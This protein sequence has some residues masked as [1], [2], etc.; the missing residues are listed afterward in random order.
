MSA[1]PEAVVDDMLNVIID[2]VE[3]KARQGAMIIEVTDDNDISVPRF[4]YHKKLPIAANCRMCMV[5]VEMGGRMA[6]KPLPACATPVADGMKVW[7]QSEY[8]R[9][10]Q[11]AVMEFLLI[12][13]PLDC[14]ICDQGGECELQDVALEYGRGVSRFSEKKRVVPEKN[15]GP[16]IASDMTRCIHCTRCVRFLEHVAGFK[17]L[18]GMGR[19]EN[20]EIG[21]CIQHNIES[22]LSGNII[23]VCPVGALTS[24]PFR[25][26]ARAWELVQTPSVA[27]HDCVGSNIYLHTRNG[28]LMR[29]VPR[30][31]EAINEVWAA[32]RDRF[33]YQGINSDDRL[34]TPMVKRA[35][36]WQEVE[37]EEALHITAQA[38]SER[39]KEQG[40]DQLGMLASP[41]ATL[42]ELSLFNQLAEGLGVSN[43][44]HRLR[45]TDF[46]GQAQ[47]PMFP[48]LGQTIEEL[49]QANAILVVGGNLRKDHPIIGHRIRKA[50]QAGASVMMINPVDYP[51]T[52][53]LAHKSIVTPSNL[54][55]SLSGVA[56]ALLQSR[57]A[58]APEA[59]Q[60]VIEQTLP[61]DT[62]QAMAA[63]LADADNATVLLGLDAMMHPAFSALRAI[64]VLIGDLSGARVGF[65]SDGA[66]SAG[67]CLAGVLPHHGAGG[68]V[69][70]NTGL[71]AAQMLAQPRRNY[72]LLNIEPEFDCAN[73]A[74]AL[75][76]MQQAGFVVALTPYVTD[77][78]RNY[79]D[80]LLP[81][82]VFAET[83]GTFVTV[84]GRWQ[85]FAAASRAPGDTRPGWKILRVLG[86]L[87]DLEGFDQVSSE[88]VRDALS[89]QVGEVKLDNSTCGDAA[90]PPAP[91][92]GLERIA[93]LP[94]YAV[95]NIVRRAESLQLTPDGQV[96]LLRLNPDDA[97]SLSLADGDR[98]TVTEDGNSVTLEVVV[99]ERVAKGAAVAPQAIE[100]TL[101]LG[102]PSGV[103]QV[104]KA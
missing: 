52:Y 44:D 78:M 16:L 80:V 56:A 90:T 86:N 72:L 65:V 71:D 48:F 102:A 6:P 43:I 88:Q 68:A 51:V 40:A 17:E 76:A 26:S 62:E 5:Q 14:P 69:R 73:G 33:S 89:Q 35:D 1:K 30:E 29:V 21:T 93:S 55:Q 50:A 95:D 87:L 41:S 31:N 13:H 3:Y 74:Q 12:N 49:E 67:A 61:N 23:D 66:N 20:V 75:A 7:T 38:L 19:G 91:A 96:A 10:A 99:D 100:A 64:A 8:A 82:A 81:S 60:A 32:D 98:A 101:K 45:Q 54:V 94:M 83:S 4:C 79:A 22:E 84:E 2:D 104:R 63:T 42:E 70:D 27:A 36:G 59:L 53:K 18:G 15:F 58:R 9:K 77:S 47:Q 24:R 103:L 37:W 39:V 46:T 92:S 11:R 85:S 57:K 28:K 25:F 34:T 97:A